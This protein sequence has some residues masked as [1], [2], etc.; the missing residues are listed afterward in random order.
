MLFIKTVHKLIRFTDV[1]MEEFKQ[2]SIFRRISIKM[3]CLLFGID[4]ETHCYKKTGCLADQKYDEEE[5]NK[6]V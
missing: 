2:S 4:L 3:I 6:N 1:S 5:R